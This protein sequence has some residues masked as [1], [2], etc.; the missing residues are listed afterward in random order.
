[1]LEPGGGISISGEGCAGES[2]GRY[3]NIRLSADIIAGI[4]CGRLSIFSVR[5]HIL[6]ILGGG[7]PLGISDGMPYAHMR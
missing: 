7:A 4:C 1:V 3:I 6:R 5:G 2:L